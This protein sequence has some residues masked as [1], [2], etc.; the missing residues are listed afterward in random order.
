MI[1]RSEARAKFTVRAPEKINYGEYYS[2]DYALS[3]LSIIMDDVY[4]DYEEDRARIAELSAKV[5]A[6]EAIIAN[7]N[8]SMAV[9]KDKESK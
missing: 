6:Y 9:V 3:I 4:K 1:T 5:T 2:K 7:S 8:F